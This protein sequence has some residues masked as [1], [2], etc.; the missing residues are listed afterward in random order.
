MTERPGEC[1][2]IH[3]RILRVT[4]AEPECRA[5]WQHVDLGV[6]V[7]ERVAMAFEQRWFGART[8]ARVRT[9]MTT[10]SQRFDATPDAVAALRAWRSIPADTRVL[11]CHWHLQFSDPVYRAFTGG[12]LAERRAEGRA[13]VDRDQVERGSM[14]RGATSALRRRWTSSRGTSSFVFG[15]STVMAFIVVPA[16]SRGKPRGLLHE[17]LSQHGGRAVDIADE[18]KPERARG[19]SPRL[20]IADWMASFVFRSCCGAS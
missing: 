16:G 14:R 12:Y 15:V 10:L 2:E 4:L 7:D 13:T 19:D 18:E 5:Y 3:T 11:V 8:I 20:L 1:A 17:E 6:P 9:L